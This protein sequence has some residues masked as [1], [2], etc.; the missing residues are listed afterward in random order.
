M[1]SFRSMICAAASSGESNAVMEMGERRSR[2]SGRSDI[3]ARHREATW[4]AC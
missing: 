1:A 4:H 3:M 2:R